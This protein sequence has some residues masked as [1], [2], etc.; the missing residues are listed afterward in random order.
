MKPI[1]LTAEYVDKILDYDSV[2]GKLTWKI[3]TG[4]KGKKGAEAGYVNNYGYRMVRVR[5]SSCSAH[6]IAWLLY[7]GKHPAGQ[8]DHV[9]GDRSNN[10]INNLRDVNPIDNSRNIKLGSR[11]KSGVLGVRWLQRQN[12]WVATIT[13]RSKRISLGYGQD[14]FHLVAARK[15]AEVRYG[16]HSNHG[17]KQVAN[18]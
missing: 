12:R 3:D 15:S 5:Y 11:N 8:I 10:S 6:R 9:D 2:S 4:V 7:Y 1:E 14:F 16:F 17:R 13:I 18:P